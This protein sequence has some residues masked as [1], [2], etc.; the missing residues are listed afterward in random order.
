MFYA[1]SGNGTLRP[2]SISK[3]HSGRLSELLM[4]AKVRFAELMAHVRMPN[5]DLGGWGVWW[6]QV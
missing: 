4:Q 6:I 3:L 2:F 5:A 1:V